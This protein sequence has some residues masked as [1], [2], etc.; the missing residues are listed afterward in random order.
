MCAAGESLQTL[1]ASLSL[2]VFSSILLMLQAI[3]QQNSGNDDS[4]YRMQL[5]DDVWRVLYLRGDFEGCE[6]EKRQALE[7]DLDEITRQTSLCVF[8]NGIRSTSCRGGVDGHGVSVKMHRT[9]VCGG[10]PV[11]VVFSL[12]K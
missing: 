9:V 11:Q 12:G 7:R 3:P 2:L 5:A 6:A 4:L 1:E 8:L 10:T